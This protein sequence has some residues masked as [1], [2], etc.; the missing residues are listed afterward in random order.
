MLS[1]D[2]AGVLVVLQVGLVVVGGG[3]KGGKK[4]CVDRVDVCNGGNSGLF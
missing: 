4:I 2:S 3:K 1:A